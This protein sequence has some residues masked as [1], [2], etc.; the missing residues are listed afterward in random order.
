[1]FRAFIRHRDLIWQMTKRDIIGRYRGSMAGLLWSFFNPVLMLSIYTDR[2][3]TR[4][5]SSH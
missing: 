1:M 2:K 3:S 5:N 4:L